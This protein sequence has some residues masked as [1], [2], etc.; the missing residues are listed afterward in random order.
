MKI[1]YKFYLYF[2]VTAL[3]SPIL[4]VE[5]NLAYKTNNVVD[6]L[7]MLL[8]L[9]VYLGL[10]LS[11]RKDFLLPFANLQAWVSGFKANQNMRL[12][13]VRDTTFQPVA[14]AIN[15]LIDENQHL[16]DDME[17]ILKKQIQRLSHKSA[18]LETLYSV[19]SKLNQ[20][21]S[22][23][24]L[25]EYFLG[26]FVS[27]TGASSGAARSLAENGELYLV[28]QYGVIDPQGQ[29]LQ[30]LN[31]DCFCGEVAMAKEAGVQFSVHSCAKCVGQ[32]S[33]QV[34]DVGTIF[35]PLRH[36]GKTLGIFNLFFDSEPSL[37]F[38]ERALLE[39]IAENIAIALDKST[40]NEQTKRMELSQERLFLSQEIHDSLAQTIYSLKLQVSVL[41]NSLKQAKQLDAYHQIEAL[42]TNITQANQELR[43]LMCNFRVPLDPKGIEVSLE[44]LVNRF[45]SE[46]GIATFLQVKGKIKVDP[47]VEMQIMRITQEALSN[48]RKHAS[49]RN[50]RIL[51]TAQPSCQLLI[52][53]DGIGFVKDSGT[54]EI[55]GNNIG[56][57]IMKERAQRIG[58]KIEVES[59]VD[60][61]TRITVNFAK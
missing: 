34:A 12:D 49:A 29:E 8:I 61:G 43:E 40:L 56:M 23:D 19:S 7:L 41:G 5:I 6:V 58:A 39:S 9:L 42:Q 38:D 10:Y 2:I 13:E 59:E 52:E 35:I 45:K 32:E 14:K 48:I 50:V 24:E 17:N 3:L 30:V 27:M 51:L 20:L 22:T 21:H 1:Q 44:N 33:R 54:S 18:S 36:H 46:E 55:M 16:Y 37:S 31:S 26:V 15:H 11:I 53:D 28:A 60:E 4:F 47:E 57:N 25:F